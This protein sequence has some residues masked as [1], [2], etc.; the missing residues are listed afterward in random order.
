MIRHEVLKVSELKPFPIREIRLDTI[1]KLTERIKERGYN[2]A[3]SLTVVKTDEG[4]FVADGNHRLQVLVNENVVDVPCVVYEGEGDIYNLAVQANVDED[5]YAPMDL[6][7][8]IQCIKKLKN[9]GF[10]QQQIGEKIGW[11]RENVKNY[12][13]IIESI[14]TDILNLCLNRQS[15]RVPKK[16]TFVPFDFSEGWFRSSGLYDLCD[17]YQIK[18]IE[19]FLTDKCNWNTSKVQS[20]SA[21][22]KLW[23]DMAVVAENKLM[24]SEDVP[25]VIKLIENGIFK[26]VDQLQSKLNDLNRKASNKLICGDCLIELENLE[27]GSIDIVITDPPYGIDYSSNRSQFNNHVAKETIENDDSL[28]IAGQLLWKTCEI[29]QRKTKSDAHIYIFCSWKN[30]SLFEDVISKHFDIKNMIV[31][32]KGN[33]GTGD[34]EGSWGNRHE[35]IIFATK[36]KRKIN[37]RKADIIAVSKVNTSDA[38]H[39]TQ[40]PEQLI[41]E[42]LQVSAQ[43]ADTV[44]DPF[45]GSGSTIKA[46]IEYGNLNYIGIELDKERFE[47]AK[48]Y[49]GGDNA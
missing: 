4:F 40:K 35:L 23:Q 12:N 47:K 34:L 16:G 36:G 31:W 27:D 1:E 19:Q 28:L 15:G 41:K 37:K 13:K 49:I 22:Y 10:T 11:S 8:Y 14:G 18:L 30:Y 39:P 48:A 38:I 9:E 2:Q 46:C 20:E 21:K 7:D 24:N 6:F 45:I 29:L 33:H 26:T 25:M 17:K 3:K 44:C 43:P 32:D 42:L 5:T